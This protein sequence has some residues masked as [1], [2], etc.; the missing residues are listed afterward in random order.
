MY[1]CRVKLHGIF[2]IQ[3]YRSILIGIFIYYVY[4]FFSEANLSIK[5]HTTKQKWIKFH[6]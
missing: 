1:I 2:H 4:V 5:F 6:L 3:N